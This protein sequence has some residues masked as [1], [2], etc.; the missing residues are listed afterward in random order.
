MTYI[1]E[2]LYVQNQKIKKY[3]IKPD[4]Q[5]LPS[6]KNRKMKEKLHLCLVYANYLQDTST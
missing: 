4:I 6:K 2:L 3:A 5:Q 1:M